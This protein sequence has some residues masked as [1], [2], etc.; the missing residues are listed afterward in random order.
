LYVFPIVMILKISQHP[1]SGT[2]ARVS[3][4]RIDGVR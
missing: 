1:S 4:S 3:R 2:E